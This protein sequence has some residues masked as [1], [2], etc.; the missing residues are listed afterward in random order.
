M[1]A[2]PPS[3]EGGARTRAEARTYGTDGSPPR[4]VR[5]RRGGRRVAKR[6]ASIRSSPQVGWVSN[7]KWARGS[8]RVSSRFHPLELGDYRPVV[9]D[10]PGDGERVLVGVGLIAA[11]FKMDQ[12]GQEPAMVIVRAS[13]SGKVSAGIASP[14]SPSRGP[15]PS[16]T[17]NALPTA[18]AWTRVQAIF[19]FACRMPP[20]YR[21]PTPA[22]HRD[23]RT[24]RPSRPSPHRP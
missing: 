1:R 11:G 24:R 15:T 6:S 17:A 10:I 18:T 4:A 21:P 8:A 22:G 3:P 19:R 14:S 13:S 7:R 5:R 23:G 12:G 16:R 20:A 9:L 2:P